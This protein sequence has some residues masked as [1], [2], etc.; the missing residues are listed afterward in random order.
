ML[1]AGLIY[2][3]QAARH[4]STGVIVPVDLVTLAETTN[5]RAAAPEPV[6]EE[7][8]PEPEPPA[9]EPEDAA[10][11]PAA[12]VPPPVEEDRPVEVI[13][14]GTPDEPPVTETPEETPEPP[15]PR[16]RPDPARQQEPVREQRQASV[17]LDYLSGLVDQARDSQ[18]RDRG[19]AE[20]GERRDG[21]GAGTAMTANL[22]DLVHSQA[23]RC[24]RGSA[25]A[26]NPERLIVQ[27]RVRLN[28][29]GSLAEPPVS[30][31]SGRIRASGDPFW[32]VAEERALAA[33]IDCAP[34]RL[35]ADQYSQWRL[36]DVTFRNNTF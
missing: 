33:I 18:P 34:F 31:N 6:I 23:V 19:N 30:V 10:V 14:D 7:A 2:L 20:A 25:D 12:A 5:V 21:A 16:E 8:P 3:P 24:Y 27:V 28:R 26:P 1:A 22:V 11:E 9:E 4:L 32:L 13:D 17:D 15:T 29:D 36:I 35:P